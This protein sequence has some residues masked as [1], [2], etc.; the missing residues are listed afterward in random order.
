MNN[1]QHG[2]GLGLTI[3]QQLVKL[4][5]PKNKIDLESKVNVGTS[6]KFQIYRELSQSAENSI[7]E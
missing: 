4:L 6:F 2:I 3:S 7:A 1:N 5:G